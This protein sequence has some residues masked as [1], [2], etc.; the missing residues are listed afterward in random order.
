MVFMAII[1]GLGLFFYILLG[2]RYTLNPKHGK[3]HCAGT[4]THLA[5]GE[6]E[7]EVSAQLGARC[8]M[9]SKLLER[10][11]IET[12]NPKSLNPNP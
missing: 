11:S 8:Y 3:G 6:T 1:M 9:F 12:L 10:G 4:L 2:F 7:R 5:A